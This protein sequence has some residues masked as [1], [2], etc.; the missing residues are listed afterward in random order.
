M[1]LKKHRNNE[2]QLADF[3]NYVDG[4]AKRSYDRFLVLKE[5][6]DKNFYAASELGD[7]HRYGASLHIETGNNYRINADF[8]K[9]ASMG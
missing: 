6:E 5:W 2:E 4:Y 9:A 1:H 8:N 3:Q 7:L